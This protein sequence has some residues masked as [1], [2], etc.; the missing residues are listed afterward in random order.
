MQNSI[1]KLKEL[2]AIIEEVDFSQLAKKL[3]LTAIETAYKIGF[4]EGEKINR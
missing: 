1:E 3:V 4:I 2:N